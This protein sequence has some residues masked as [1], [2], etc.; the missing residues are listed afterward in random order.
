LILLNIKISAMTNENQ[1]FE[2]QEL[3]SQLSP[4][5]QAIADVIEDLIQPCAAKGT[6]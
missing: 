6:A 5:E 4:E 2:S 1:I 3:I